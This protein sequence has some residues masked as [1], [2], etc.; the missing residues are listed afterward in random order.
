MTQNGLGVGLRPTG[1]SGEAGI[2]RFSSG[3]AETLPA[4]QTSLRVP[5]GQGHGERWRPGPYCALGLPGTPVVP[6]SGDQEN[7]HRV[8]GDK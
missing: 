8:S 1:Q 7:Q 6:A 2:T 5:R 4:E 3:R